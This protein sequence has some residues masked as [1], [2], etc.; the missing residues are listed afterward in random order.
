MGRHYGIDRSSNNGL[1]TDPAA[2]RAAYNYLVQIGGG[3]QPFLIE[4]LGEGVGYINP[5]EHPEVVVA[6]PTGFALAAYGFAHLDR[7]PPASEVA[8][9]RAHNQDGLPIEEDWEVGGTGTISSAIAELSDLGSLAL[10]YGNQSYLS[11]AQ[12]RGVDLANKGWLAEYDGRVAPRIPCVLYQYTDALSVPGIGACDGNVFL[13]SEA[14]FASLFANVKLVD[15]HVVPPVNPP[16]QGDA[17]PMQ[18]RDPK[19]GCFVVVDASGG[20]ATFGPNGAPASAD[21]ASGHPIYLGS[22][23]GHP[24]YHAGAGQPEG[25]VVAVNH[26]DDGNPHASAY[27]LVTKDAAGRYHPYNFPSDGS[28][29]K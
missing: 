26:Y 12:S 18:S 13:G 1:V 20:V 2:W 28:L 6:K 22:L 21:P 23:P 11:V 27:V 16:I 15:P 4:K 19:N 10:L 17:E 9:W 14:Q 5:D 8:Y 24:E 3:A 29:A 25:P 7:D